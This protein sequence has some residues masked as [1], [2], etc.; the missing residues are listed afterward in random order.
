M[1]SLTRRIATSTSNQENSGDAETPRT[2]VLV[3]EDDTLLRMHAAEMIE[4][5]GFEVIEARNADEAIV[6]LEGRIDI[7]IVFTDIDMPGSMNGLKLA[8]AVANRWPPIRIVATSGHFQ[9]RDGDLPAG[10]RFIAKPYRS[11][12]ILAML[13]ELTSANL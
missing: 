7:A 3:V 6:V 4:E 12:Q 8:H 5:A 9:M 13:S 10:G 2:V 11:Q 1:T